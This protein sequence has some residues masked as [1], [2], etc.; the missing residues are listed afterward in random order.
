MNKFFASLLCCS[1]TLPLL[2]QSEQNTPAPSQK[3]LSRKQIAE[4]GKQ[5]KTPS[6]NS[7]IPKKTTSTS[8]GSTK[9]PATASRKNIVSNTANTKPASSQK[10]SS[11]SG[12]SNN[13]TVLLTA[14]AESSTS[15]KN[16]DSPALQECEKEPNSFRFS[17]VHR[18][19]KGIGYPEGYTSL[20]MFFS[21]TS[22]GNVR[23]FFDIRGHMSN[24][25]KPAANVGFGVRYLPDSINAI[26]GLNTFF[27]FR[28]ARHS[29]YEQMGVGLEI[30][31]TQWGFHANG[32]FP[33]IK[34][35]NV[36]G[37][38]FFEFQGHSAFV[39]LQREIALTGFDASIERSLVHRGFFDLDA[40]L[41]TYYFQGHRDLKAPGGYVKLKSSLS[42]YITVDVQGSYDSLYKW[43][44]QGAAA[45]NI[46][47]GKRVKTG[48]PKRTCYEET[49]LA[50][51]LTDP[52]ARFE[53]IV[54]HLDQQTVPGLDPRTNEPISI[55]F[56]NNTAG[57]GGN[58]TV[59]SPYNTLALAETN[60]S[61]GEMIYV[62]SGDGTDSGMAAGITLQNSQW[63]QSSAFD[64]ELLTAYGPVFVPPFTS[65]MPVISSLGDG[66]T[67]ANGNIVNGFSINAASNNIIG[68]GINGTQ[69]TNNYLAG[70][71]NS[72]IG[73]ESVS[74]EIIISGNT[75]TSGGSFSNF[76]GLGIQ[77]SGGSFDANIFN[78]TF[79]NNA[80]GANSYNIF[81]ATT[82]TTQADLEI[83][84]NSTQGSTNGVGLLLDDTASV[85]AVVAGNSFFNATGS[86]SEMSVILNSNSSMDAH[87]FNNTFS[88]PLTGL[89]I[90]TSDSSS[91]TFA[92]LR[93]M[94]VDGSPS[95]SGGMDFVTNDSSLMT[96]A[97]VNNNS[98]AP[99]GYF[100]DNTSGSATLNVQSPTLSITGVQNLNTGTVETSG[101]IT[102]LPLDHSNTK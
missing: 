76:V 17:F 97:L 94:V 66:V 86:G 88:S 58:G 61:P 70:A 64:F 91:G 5:T 52:V 26:F 24:D 42:R 84:D 62:Y 56:V 98:N 12:R 34:T 92:V 11:S 36:I 68:L 29:T 59:E 75:S 18:E 37:L 60:S 41:G 49:A 28:Q 77:N 1:L 45:L 63:L 2:L 46:P 89:L 74:G 57:S 102:F 10:R 69:I 100:L 23:P 33:L 40:Y 21:F 31:G 65:Q 3:K 50:R 51:N 72:D 9:K 78:N 95:L 53:M 38:H 35:E 4:A 79:N 48:N 8:Q 81:I 15:Q 14:D 80:T 43:I 44:F 82:G 32:Y 25:G 54:T 93:N 101:T 90:A 20:D 27:D 99:V 30:L 71:S 73:L 47:F 6:V 67:L 55:V 85:V 16:N 39:H 87:I 7:S 13:R 96:L 19:G 83:Q 22:I